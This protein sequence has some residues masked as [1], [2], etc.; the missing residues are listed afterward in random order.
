MSYLIWANNKGK[1]G[2]GVNLGLSLRQRPVLSFDYTSLYYESDVGNAFKFLFGEKHMLTI[3]EIMSVNNYIDSL[4]YSISTKHYV[5]GKGVYLGC[6][7]INAIEVPSAPPQNGYFI[8]RDGDWTP[9]IAV[10]Q[11]GRY[12]GNVDPAGDVILVDAP[13]PMPADHHRWDTQLKMWIDI[14]PINDIKEELLHDI[15]ERAAQARGYHVTITTGMSE[16]YAMKA[17]EAERWLDG[18]IDSEMDCPMLTAE[19]EVILITTGEEVTITEVAEIILRVR[20]NTVRALADIERVRRIGKESVKS[21]DDVK[22]AY[23]AHNLCVA[24]IDTKK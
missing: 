18:R 11:D 10:T 19:A 21:A 6:G 23:E 3:D 7:V 16:I 22:T 5:D 17:S 1:I 14:R 8:W 2:N 12:L 4:D 15:D 13:P 9:V 24:A 20:T